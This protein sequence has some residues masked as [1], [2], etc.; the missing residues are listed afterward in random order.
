MALR[1]AG[2][3]GLMHWEAVAGPLYLKCLTVLVAL[4]QGIGLERHLVPVEGKGELVGAAESPVLHQWGKWTLA[5]PVTEQ[6]AECCAG[7]RE[8]GSAAWRWWES[9]MKGLEF[10]VNNKDL[11]NIT[12]LTAQREALEQRFRRLL[13]HFPRVRHIA[14]SKYAGEKNE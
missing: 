1:S 7:L 11:Q 5:Q 13:P 14:S 2:P 12:V 10:E 8:Q 6:S 4:G 9:F 3:Q